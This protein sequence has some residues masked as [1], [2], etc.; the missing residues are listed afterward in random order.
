VNKRRPDAHSGLE[1][2]ARVLATTPPS[3]SAL[4][5]SGLMA[6]RQTSRMERTSPSRCARV[7]SGGTCEGSGKC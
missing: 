5:C 7:R 4:Q 2:S 1:S 3:S 6:S